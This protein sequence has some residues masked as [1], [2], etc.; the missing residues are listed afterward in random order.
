VRYPH[1]GPRGTTC[2][3]ASCRRW[4]RLF[5]RATLLCSAHAGRYKAD[6]LNAIHAQLKSRR[7]EKVIGVLEEMRSTYLTQFIKLIE[8]VSEAMVEANDNVKFLQPLVVRARAAA[9]CTCGTGRGE[10]S[11]GGGV[12]GGL[13]AYGGGVHAAAS[14]EAGDGG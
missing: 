9:R 1:N 3:A 4:S 12:L 11:A 13:T 10:V 8:N 6:N 2:V 5:T 14:H 7:V